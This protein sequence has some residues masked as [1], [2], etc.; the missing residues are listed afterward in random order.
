M[1]ARYHQAPDAARAALTVREPLQPFSPAAFGA[2]DGADPAPEPRRYSY[3]GEWQAAAQAG[4]EARAEPAPWIDGPLAAVDAAAPRIALADLRAFLRDPPGAFLRQRLNLR[5]PDAGAAMDDV[6]PLLLPGRGL[7]RQQ[8]QQAVYEALLAGRGE[9]LQAQLRA[10]A[11]LP[12]GPLGRRQLDSLLAEVRPYADAF[13]H[14][15]QQ[16]APQSQRFE[17][18][19]EAGRL[20]GRVDDLYAAGLARLRFGKLHGP[21]QIAHGLDWLVLSALGDPRPLAQCA[22][23]AGGVGPM[24]RAAAD[25]AQARAAL[26][27]LLRLRLHGLREPLPFLPRAGWL[28]YAAEAE[29]RDAWPQAAL[30]WHGGSHSWSEA[31]ASGARLALRG[32]D[33]FA[34][35][36]EAELAEE[37]RAIARLVFDAVVHARSEDA[38]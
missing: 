24:L 3:R 16:Q 25:P 10:R 4:G 20:H 14:W 22:V 36:G 34:G 26:D 11:L 6:E 37:F 2:G 32:R 30:Q 27:A 12:S 31:E 38:R 17:L 19:L 18:E 1:A 5:L 7:Q 28:W 23:A 9:T 35:A 15:R 13:A 29:G 8:L 21:A 33:P